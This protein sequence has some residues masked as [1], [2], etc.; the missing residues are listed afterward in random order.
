MRRVYDAMRGGDWRTLGE[1]ELLTGDPQASVSA[2]LRD[3]RKRYGKDNLLRRPRGNRS[4]GLFEY[5][6]TVPR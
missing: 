1:I 2:R 3:L 6:L 5:R 4:N